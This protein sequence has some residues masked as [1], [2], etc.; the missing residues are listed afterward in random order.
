MGHRRVESGCLNRSVL[1]STS[2]RDG[3]RAKD[4]AEPSNMGRAQGTK[5][6]TRQQLGK[7]HQRS[8]APACRKRP[9]IR[10]KEHSDEESPIERASCHDRWQPDAEG[11]RRHAD[12]G[13]MSH[14]HPALEQASSHGIANEP[15]RAST[16]LGSR[17][18]RFNKA[19]GHGVA[20]VP[21]SRHLVE[22]PGK[23]T[24]IRVP[25]RTPA[26]SA[27][28]AAPSSSAPPRSRCDFAPPRGSSPSPRAPWHAG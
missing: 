5:R 4:T 7:Q 26:R 28:P 12:C 11:H 6:H 3:L 25:P 1:R 24:A 22:S 17:R 18:M 9:P 19:P 10:S 15:S 8:G 13:V 14:G 16:R 2:H 23:T 20:F 21:M 27:P